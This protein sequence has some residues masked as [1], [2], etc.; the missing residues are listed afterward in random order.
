MLSISVIAAFPELV[1]NALKYGVTGRARE[2]G[3]WRWQGFPLHDFAMDA[4]KSIDARPAAG[5]PGMVLMPA[6]LDAAL[7]A[8]RAWHGERSTV[9]FMSPDGATLNQSRSRE[10]AKCNHLTFVAGRY[11][12]IDQRWIDENVDAIVSIGDYVLSG[13]E[14]PAAVV[15]DSCVRLIPD[16]LGDDESATFE[17]FSDG[18]LDWPQYAVAATAS[19]ENIPAELAKGDH[20]EIDQ[21][22]R[23]EALLRTWK[24]RPD[25][26]LNA[27]LTFEEQA[28]IQSAAEFDKPAQNELKS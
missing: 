28:M 27:H 10:L 19:G 8:A 6:P 14:L 24:R 4:R 2:L 26:L 15:I 23:R 13:G 11:E 3:L 12:G 9:V 7:A 25:L 16:A 1:E 5:G 21:W 17:S 20:A 18:R 22:R